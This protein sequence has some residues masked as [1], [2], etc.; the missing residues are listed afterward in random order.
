MADGLSC[1]VDFDLH[2]Q[3]PGYCD[4]E[5]GFCPP[6]PPAQSS[7]TCNSRARK[8]LADF[9]CALIVSQPIGDIGVCLTN[10][11]CS[12]FISCYSQTTEVQNFF[13]GLLG[14]R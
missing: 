1:A 11:L 3:Y 9:D 7:P 12:D 13:S 6:P 14:G 2:G 10:K 8:C 4:F 5:C